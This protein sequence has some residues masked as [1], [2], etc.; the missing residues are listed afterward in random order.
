[1]PVSLEDYAISVTTQQS[2]VAVAL[3]IDAQQSTAFR[4]ASP[5]GS[6]NDAVSFDAYRSL[7]SSATIAIQKTWRR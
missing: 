1:M 4:F 3:R 2:T 7:A 5:Y 6:S